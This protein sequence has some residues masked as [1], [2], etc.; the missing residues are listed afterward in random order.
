MVMAANL[1]YIKSRT[2]LPMDQQMGEEDADEDDPHWE[3][4]RQ[5]VE[6]KKFKKAA[7]ASSPSAQGQG[8]SAVKNFT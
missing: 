1:L 2:L 6:Y 8:G 7:E 3:L 4:I 5:L